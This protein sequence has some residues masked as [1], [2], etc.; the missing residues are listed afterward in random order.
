MSSMRA[1]VKAVALLL[2][3]LLAFEAFGSFKH[4][5]KGL[6]ARDVRAGKVGQRVQSIGR[7]AAEHLY[8]YDGDLSNEDRILARTAE[9]LDGLVRR[10]KVAA[11]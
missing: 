2:V 6:S 1:T 4:E 7:L 10:F 11:V 5:V 8:V 9:E 3:T